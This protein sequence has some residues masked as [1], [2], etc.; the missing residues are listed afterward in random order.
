M[1]YVGPLTRNLSATCTDQCAG[2]EK[3]Q[4]VYATMYCMELPCADSILCF[5]HITQLYITMAD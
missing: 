1:D 2:A 5:F 3:P 4:E